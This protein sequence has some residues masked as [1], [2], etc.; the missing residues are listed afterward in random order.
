MIDMLLDNNNCFLGLVCIAKRR[1][2]GR[3]TILRVT[4]QY[5]SSKSSTANYIVLYIYQIRGS[6]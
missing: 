3:K 5:I 6:K 4:L 1:L 2:V